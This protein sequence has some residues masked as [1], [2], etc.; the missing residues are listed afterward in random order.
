MKHITEHLSTG[1]EIEI[2][3][4]NIEIFLGCNF[5]KPCGWDIEDSSK[6]HVKA[7]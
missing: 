1:I 7:W 3:D 6:L 4:L 5:S 2:L